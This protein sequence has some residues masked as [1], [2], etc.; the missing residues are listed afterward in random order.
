MEMCKNEEDKLWCFFVYVEMRRAKNIICHQQKLVLHEHSENG[1][2]TWG[3]EKP[4][5]R[6]CLQS[7][8]L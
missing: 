1:I 6:Y 2:E 3:N 5:V 4:I 8:I 7:L